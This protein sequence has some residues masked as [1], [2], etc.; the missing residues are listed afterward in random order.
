M[1]G[2][3]IITQ[4]ALQR[5]QTDYFGQFLLDNARLLEELY[6][7]L[8]GETLVEERQVIDGQHVLV[9]TWKK[10]PH[11]KPVMSEIGINMTMRVLNLTLTSNNATGKMD[12]DVLRTLA[13][14]TYIQLVQNY[15]IYF[16]EC[17]FQSEMDMY[18]TAHL[19]LTNALLHLSKSTDMALL[20]ELMSSYNILETRGKEVKPEPQPSMT[21]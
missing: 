5:M 2:E 14:K 19:V 7:K 8:K 17:G 10:V 15:A 12:D 3:N 11:L 4:E 18:Q 20:R 13:Y 1:A 21:L 9:P 16:E 6:H